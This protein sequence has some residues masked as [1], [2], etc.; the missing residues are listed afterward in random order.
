MNY[1][2]VTSNAKTWLKCFDYSYFV[3]G[4]VVENMPWGIKHFRDDKWYCLSSHRWEQ[5]EQDVFLSNCAR[6]CWHQKALPFQNPG[7]CSTLQNKTQVCQSRTQFLPLW[8][9]VFIAVPRKKTKLFSKIFLLAMLPSLSSCHSMSFFAVSF[10]LARAWDNAALIKRSD[11]PVHRSAEFH[12]KLKAA[13]LGQSLPFTCRL[14]ERQQ[15][16]PLKTRQ[17]RELR[18]TFFLNC[19]AANLTVYTRYS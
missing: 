5:T 10:N 3:V 12:L 1:S 14:Q 17:L 19:Q 6:W 11:I 7:W 13:F 9:N 18:W 16:V 4:L 8:E 15:H 2:V